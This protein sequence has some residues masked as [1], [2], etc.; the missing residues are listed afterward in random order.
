MSQVTKKQERT[1]RDPCKII[2]GR[3]AQGPSP[4][5]P[6]IDREKEV[7]DTSSATAAVWSVTRHFLSMEVCAPHRIPSS[8]PHQTRVKPRP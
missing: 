6:S 1:L 8:L 5:S 7:K 2:H 3:A 4:I